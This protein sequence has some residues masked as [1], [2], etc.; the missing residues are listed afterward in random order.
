VQI[1]AVSSALA[2]TLF[3]PN[4]KFSD[5]DPESSLS[6]TLES[7]CSSQ[8]EDKKKPRDENMHSSRSK[9]VRVFS[10]EDN[11]NIPSYDIN[12]TDE[13]VYLLF[14]AEDSVSIVTVGKIDRLVVLDIKWTRQNKDSRFTALPTV[15]L[16]SPPSKSHFWRWHNSGDG[17]LSTI[18]AVYFAAMDVTKNCWTTLERLR[19]INIMWLFSLQHSIIN[20]RSIAEQRPVPFSEEGK[21]KARLLRQRHPDRKIK[22]KLNQKK[23]NSR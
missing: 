8:I 23:D 21:A 5:G 3:C 4:S 6:E 10:L 22:K 17:M 1:A 20:K 7:V 19:L 18:E 9:S 2:S 14:P 11:N 15:H 13:K 12:P 16:D